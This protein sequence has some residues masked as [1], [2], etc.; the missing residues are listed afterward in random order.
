MAEPWGCSIDSF[1]DRTS[2][3]R[4]DWIG[5]WVELRPHQPC[6]VPGQ[7][8]AR[9]EV[10]H[11]LCVAELGAWEQVS[12]PDERGDL[13]AVKGA[14]PTNA[15][16]SLS[17]VRRSRSREGERRRRWPQTS[18]TAQY[19]AGL[20]PPES[21]RPSGP[22]GGRC[23]CL[24]GVQQA[25]AGALRLAISG[26]IPLGCGRARCVLRV[27]GS[28]RNRQCDR[29]RR[30]CCSRACN[31]RARGEQRPR[32]TGCMSARVGPISL[33]DTQSL[34]TARS[35]ASS[36]PSRRSDSSSSPRRRPSPDVAIAA[37]HLAGVRGSRNHAFAVPSPDPI[38]EPH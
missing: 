1:V 19:R 33:I 36:K 31:L 13:S 15:P 28:V 8:R 27:A 23:R 18:A 16:V 34:G 10:E 25:V 5:R 20:R 12:D 26:V 7:W 29:R 9:T 14:L 4:A 22:T 3:Q 2:A 11:A 17:Q 35:S 30:G 32:R 38:Y 21:Q 37:N 6:V 24:A